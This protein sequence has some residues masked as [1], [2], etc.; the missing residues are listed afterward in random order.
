MKYRLSKGEKVIFNKDFHGGCRRTGVACKVL[1]G[2]TGVVKSKTVKG[3]LITVRFNVG[4]A[5]IHIP[6]TNDVI[7]SKYDAPKQR[8]LQ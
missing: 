7:D 2:T 6:L 3:Y 8:F 1:K 5:D 4:S